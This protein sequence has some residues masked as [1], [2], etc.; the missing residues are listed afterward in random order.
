MSKTIET[1]TPV[2]TSNQESPINGDDQRKARAK[3]LGAAF[4]IKV[5]TDSGGPLVAYIKKPSREVVE[6]V[7]S[8]VAG[9]AA[10][11]GEMRMIEAGEIVLRSGWIAEVSDAAILDDQDTL[12]TASMSA[13]QTVNIRL[14]EVEKL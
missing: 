7:F 12:I 9:A 11:I 8:R 5:P 13:Y 6:Q 2:T 10:G 3:S 4:E 1:G 14:G